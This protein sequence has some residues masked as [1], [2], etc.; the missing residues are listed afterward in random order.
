MKIPT[1]LAGPQKKFAVVGETKKFYVLKKHK[2]SLKELRKHISVYQPLK[3]LLLSKSLRFLSLTIPYKIVDT[4]ADFIYEG[5]NTH[6]FDFEGKTVT[7]VFKD[8][9]DMK[10]NAK[11]IKRLAGVIPYPTI[12][13]KDNKQ[14]SITTKYIDFEFL[15]IKGFVGQTSELLDMRRVIKGTKTA[16]VA[17]K[18]FLGTLQESQR[19]LIKKRFKERGIDV[20]KIKLVRSH[21]DFHPGKIPRYAARFYLLDFDSI[22]HLPGITDFINFAFLPVHHN[23][24]DARW[25]QIVFER[26]LEKETTTP[27]ELVIS[28][29]MLHPE[30]QKLQNFFEKK[31][32]FMDL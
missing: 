22:T 16:D 5:N 6:F 18:K 7:T 12:L 17:V 1:E 3:G 10:Q 32:L 2:K 20:K 29:S 15:P 28:L 23:Q 19:T 24:S 26:F 8:L 4:T 14:R 21:G 31:N 13:N 9:N 30:N 27:A 25:G 11:W